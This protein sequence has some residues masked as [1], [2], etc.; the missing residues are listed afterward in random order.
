MVGGEYDMTDI[1]RPMSLETEQHLIG[2]VLRGGRKTYE[3]VKDFIGSEM[4]FSVSHRS[5][6]EGMD[7]I[8]ANGMQLDVVIVGDEMERMQAMGELEQEWGNGVWSGRA[9]L[10]DLRQNGDP[11]NVETYAEQVQD[12]HIKRHLLDYSSK[13]AYWSAN[14]R[15]GKD[16]MA[17]VEA[18]LAKITIFSARDEHTV[19]MADAVSKAYDW[20]DRAARGEVV[21]VPTGL[22]DVDKIL[23]TMIAGNVYIMAGRPGTGKTAFAL[24]VAMNQ[25]KR[26]KRIGIFSL[27]MSQEQVAM[28]LIAQWSGI[29]LQSIIQGTLKE[30]EWTLYTDAV[31]NVAAL[32]I[33]VNDLSS[34]NISQIRQ[35][36]RR[37]LAESGIDLLIVDYVQLASAEGKKYERREQEVSAVSR[38]L[39]YLASELNV[40]VLAMAQL[41]RAVEARASRRPVLSDLRESGSL[42]QDGYCVM[43][44]YREDETDK[45]KQNI[46]SLNVAKHRN[47][48][49]G[50]CELF[51][52]APIAKFEN[53]TTRVF[54][55]GGL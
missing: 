48:P 12:Y 35:T 53:A 29:D 21:G 46:V 28:R 43:F 41:S 24:S 16:I 15:R 52:N 37:M 44:L 19:S 32:P 54:S 50:D 45:A 2:A 36:A 8:Y 13:I 20:T 26:G 6:W 9:Y 11:R 22:M 4:F 38:G 34:I 5:V 25:A 1:Q 47:G 7:K 42:E 27:E 10:A 3:K 39:K 51:F 14:G 33:V 31:E 49:V 23:G 40:P 18:E 55:T 30:N 17:D